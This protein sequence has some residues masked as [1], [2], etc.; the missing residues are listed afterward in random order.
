MPFICKRRSDI[1]DGTLQITD[2]W[3][4]KA[5]A[6]A[7]RD[8]RP[9]GSRYLRGAE[10]N[11]V[12]LTTVGGV[13][14]F[15]AAYSGL[16]AYLLVNVGGGL[17]GSTALT[18]AEANTI[19]A[20]LITRM[21]TGA[22]MA[23]ADINAVIAA[24]VAGAA[25]T[26][27]GTDSTGAVTDVLRILAGATYTVPAGTQIRAAGPVFNPQADPP[28]FNASCFAA[29]WQDI[30]VTDNSFYISLTQGQIAKFLDAAYSFQGTTGP[31]IAVYDDAGGAY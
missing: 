21:E 1:A 31:A 19:A 24:T 29:V 10:T 12:V 27:G 17:A 11:N 18:T 8:P 7:V 14:T 9:Q 5:Q 30:L 25:L 2:F 15:A 16:A 20:A 28:A 6:N 4:N 3:P 23:L 13:Q 22:A 26:A